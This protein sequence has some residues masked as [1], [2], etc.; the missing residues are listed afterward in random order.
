MLWLLKM[1]GQM[2]GLTVL[3]SQQCIVCEMT[4]VLLMIIS[5]ETEFVNN[6]LG[7]L[8]CAVSVSIST[9]RR[10]GSQMKMQYIM[11]SS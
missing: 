11:L 4:S 6:R 7:V 10:H 5:R 2:T 3:N 9:R 8:G 1:Y